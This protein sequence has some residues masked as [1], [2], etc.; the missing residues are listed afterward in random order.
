MERGGGE[1]DLASGYPHLV[2]EKSGMLGFDKKRRGV[3]VGQSTNSE[4]GTRIEDKS[5][6]SSKERIGTRGVASTSLCLSLTHHVGS[7]RGG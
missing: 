7:W 3:L 2:E 6:R 1:D 5:R 4:H